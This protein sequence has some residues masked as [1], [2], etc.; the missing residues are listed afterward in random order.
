M[1]LLFL[2]LTSSQGLSS[3]VFLG[4]ER[5]WD[6][7]TCLWLLVWETRNWD[8]AIAQLPETIKY[9]MD[10]PL[11]LQDSSEH[12]LLNW[13]E[14]IGMLLSGWGWPSL[15]WVRPLHSHYITAQSWWTPLG[16]SIV[17]QISSS[18]VLLKSLIDFCPTHFA[19]LTFA[20]FYL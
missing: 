14:V 6:Q 9:Q 11:L 15:S 8:I 2:N 20:S 1:A 10:L 3:I 13:S 4:H 7:D 19:V 16:Y 12:L 17:F 5:T 18:F